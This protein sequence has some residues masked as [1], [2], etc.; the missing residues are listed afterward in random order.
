VCA[1]GHREGFVGRLTEDS[2]LS[3]WSPT[4]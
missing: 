4:F 1:T 2:G 3:D